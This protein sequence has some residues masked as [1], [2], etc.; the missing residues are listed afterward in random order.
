[1]NPNRKSIVITITALGFA[2]G[3]LLAATL[4]PAD[5]EYLADYEKIRAAL[6]ADD[7]SGAQKAAE[8]LGSA[9]AAIASSKSLE[10]ARQS[11]AKLSEKAEKLTAGQP[12]F[13]AVHCPMAKKDWVQTS[14]QISNP[15]LG[16]KMAGCGEIK[17]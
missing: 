2:I 16:K 17:K 1:M 5:K 15:Y 4:S 12:G 6:A 8:P 7:L 10:E 9:G 14:E 3:S 13:Y 11:F